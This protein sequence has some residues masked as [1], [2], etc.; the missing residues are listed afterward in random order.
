MLKSF[1]HFCNY[2]LIR[3]SINGDEEVRTNR[4]STP[5]LRLDAFELFKKG[6]GK[7]LNK[8]FLQNK[9]V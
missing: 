2:C 7:E 5:P 6:K 9:G 4:P 8:I 1:Y 3:A